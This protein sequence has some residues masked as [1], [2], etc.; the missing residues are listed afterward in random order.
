MGKREEPALTLQA[1]A[2][3]IAAGRPID[4][5]LEV[6][7]RVTT[8]PRQWFSGSRGIRMATMARIPVYVAPSWIFVA[9]ILLF[10][11]ASMLQY[12]VADLAIAPAYLLATVA[13]GLVFGSVL[14][15]ELAHA[16]L[17]RRYGVPVEAVTLWMLG[18]YTEMR[19]ELPTPRG[20]FLVAAA[21]PVTSAILGGIG[22]M[23]AAASVGPPWL[24]E[25]C[26]YV[27]F[28]NFIIAVFNALPGLPL[29]GG[30]M[31]R[32]VMWACTGN[33]LRA[34]VAAA[35]AGQTVAVILLGFALGLLYTDIGINAG[36]LVVA[37]VVPFFLWAA[38]SYTVRRSHITQRIRRLSARDLA[39]S[40]ALVPPG[41]SLAHA[42]RAAEDT[43]SGVIVVGDEKV[44]LGVVPGAAVAAT[45]ASR[46]DH[47]NV[48]QLARAIDH[49]VVVPAQ[50]TGEQML[51]LL[52]SDSSVGGYVVTEA[53]E[54]S[55][56]A[57]VGVLNERDFAHAAEPPW[58]LRS[59]IGE[60]TWL[61]KPGA[62]GSRGV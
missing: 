60:L 46:R 11:Y 32:A 21:G 35:R 24:A 40:A 20:E 1:F 8:G 23:G 13:V 37:F 58:R 19:R 2:S 14:L 38:A 34:T 33:Q 56:T 6:I 26:G 7:R 5:P 45:P 22:A 53:A 29:D 48:G 30:V 28:A 52:T 12:R 57:F 27:A 4:A 17:A 51:E 55:T 3:P 39:T 49:T 62:K 41:T 9:A 42:L 50:A 47:I 15:H 36:V 31:V 59:A 18:G 16:L 25:I 10:S 54:L 43:A 44:L 61:M